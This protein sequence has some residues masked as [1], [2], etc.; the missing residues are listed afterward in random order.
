M[1]KRQYS[2]GMGKIELLPLFIDFKREISVHLF[3]DFI[4]IWFC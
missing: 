4:F 3:K 2:V 1:V